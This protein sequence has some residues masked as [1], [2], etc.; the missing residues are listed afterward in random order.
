MELTRSNVV[1][2]RIALVSY[3]C[4]EIKILGKNGKTPEILIWQ[5]THGARRG[6]AGSSHNPQTPPGCGLG[7]AAPGAHLASRWLG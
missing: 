3:F 1:F 5:K 4:A 7:L 6:A 2:S